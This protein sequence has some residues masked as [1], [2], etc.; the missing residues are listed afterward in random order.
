[1]WRADDEA[2]QIE[3]KG[4]NSDSHVQLF[5][6]VQ[7]KRGYFLPNIVALYSTSLPLAAWTEVR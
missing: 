4:S 3:R 6:H 1:M 7:S 2:R 5:D